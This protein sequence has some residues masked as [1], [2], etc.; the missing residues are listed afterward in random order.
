M[1]LLYK[2]IRGRTL[3]PEQYVLVY[4]DLI[5]SIVYIRW[6]GTTIKKK[7]SRLM[8]SRCIVLEDSSATA[9]QLGEGYN[10]VNSANNIATYSLVWKYEL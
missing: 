10:I 7:L 1:I 2:L 3:F 9:K 8:V 6:I 4:K 5:S